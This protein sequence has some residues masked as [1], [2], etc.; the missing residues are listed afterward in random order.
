MDGW[1]RT[2]RSG[3][4]ADFR[5]SNKAFPLKILFELLKLM[6]ALPQT[7]KGRVLT[8]VRILL[9]LQFI[10]M[11]GRHF[12]AGENGYT[13]PQTRGNTQAERLDLGRPVSVP[14]TRDF[15]RGSSLTPELNA[16]LAAVAQR[17]ALVDTALLDG[18]KE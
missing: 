1:V 3:T 17:A 15:P 7:K 5:I 4:H 10:F 2:R 13:V 14:A 16:N 6:G 8:Q 11:S 18:S 9:F 12:D